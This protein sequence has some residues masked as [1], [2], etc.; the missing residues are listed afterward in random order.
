MH[1]VYLGNDAREHREEVGKW[2]REEIKDLIKG[3]FLLGVT[4][5]LSHCGACGRLCETGRV[6]V[7]RMGEEGEAFIHELM[8]PLAG[9]SFLGL[10]PPGLCPPFVQARQAP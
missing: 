6:I 2:A 8:S 1:V 3:R 10:T 9:G 5:A 7:L 4:E